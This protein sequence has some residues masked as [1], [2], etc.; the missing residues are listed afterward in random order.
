MAVRPLPHRRV[1]PVSSPIHISR[2]NPVFPLC[3]RGVLAAF[4]YLPK[5]GEDAASTLSLELDQILVLAFEDEFT[6]LIV[7][8]RP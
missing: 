5:R 4:G 7:D 1:R 2:W 6:F 8:G 3:R